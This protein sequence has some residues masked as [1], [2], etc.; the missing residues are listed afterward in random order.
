MI[1]T[2]IYYSVHARDSLLTTTRARLY[3]TRLLSS[4]SR[5]MRH[6]PTWDNRLQNVNYGSGEGAGVDGI[7]ANTLSLMK[8]VFTHGISKSPRTLSQYSEP[9]L[10]MGSHQGPSYM[11]ELRIW[12]S[13]TLRKSTGWNPRARLKPPDFSNTGGSIVLPTA[14]AGLLGLRALFC[15]AI[16]E[17][18]SVSE[19]WPRAPGAQCRTAC[20]GV[21][22]SVAGC[23]TMN[24]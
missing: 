18:Q 22:Q 10:T 6:R 3:L 19:P 5:I 9:L 15:E 12:K 7:L 4:Q 16:Q 17:K 13:S 1:S 24:A 21:A 20:P 8:Y 23:T 11:S 14:I 2:P